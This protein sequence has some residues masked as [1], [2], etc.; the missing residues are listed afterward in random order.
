MGT[1][2]NS[3]SKFLVVTLIA[4]LQCFAP[5]IHAHTRGV[6]ADH[7]IHFHG[8]ETGVVAGAAPDVQVIGVAQQHGPAIGVAKEYKRDNTLPSF[9]TPLLSRFVALPQTFSLH[10]DVWRLFLA[11]GVRF[12][13]PSAQAP[14]GISV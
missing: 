13:R 6:P 3:W 9:D 8:D 14:P 7:D 12:T 11:P 1:M 10:P 5:L 4:G 2:F